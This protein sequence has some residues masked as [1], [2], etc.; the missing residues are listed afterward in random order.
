MVALLFGSALAPPKIRD[1]QLL[2][3]QAVKIFPPSGQTLARISLL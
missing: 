3:Q 1:T 2:L